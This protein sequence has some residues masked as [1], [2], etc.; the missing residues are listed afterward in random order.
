MNQVLTMSWHYAENYLSQ[1]LYEELMFIF[2]ILKMRK[3][4]YREAKAQL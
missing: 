4:R 1:Q 2:P 3:L